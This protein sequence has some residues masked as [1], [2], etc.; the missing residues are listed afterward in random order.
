MLQHQAGLQMDQENLLDA[1]DQAVQ[2]RDFGIG[3][4]DA[5]GFEPPLQPAN[6]ERAF[7]HLVERFNGR[8]KYFRDRTPD[9]RPHHRKKRL[10]QH[11]RILAHGFADG[12]FDR[13]RER[14]AQRRI[15]AMRA[16]EFD[17]LGDYRTHI[18]RAL[19][20]IFQ[21]FA[22][23]DD[24]MLFFAEQERAQFLEGF[25][26]V[27]GR[28]GAR[29]TFR[30]VCALVAHVWGG[31]GVC[32]LIAEP[33]SGRSAG[34]REARLFFGQIEFVLQAHAEFGEEIAQA[35]SIGLVDAQRFDFLVEQLFHIA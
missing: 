21:A 29:R 9:R 17:G 23:R 10:D 4:A 22:K 25:F 24:F 32:K 1:V 19:F 26:V 2:Q 15:A 14:G 3:P 18:G 8:A 12:A 34:W 27:L 16:A 28:A 30:V 31:H 5:H 6:R 13:G 11:V 7:Q 35:L 20:G 33:V